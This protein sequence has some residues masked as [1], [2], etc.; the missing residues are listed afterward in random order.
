MDIQKTIRCKFKI[1]LSKAGAYF[2]K[3]NL[4]MAYLVGVSIFFMIASILTEVISRYFFLLEPGDW[5]YNR[6]NGRASR[7]CVVI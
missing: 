3:F 4:L 6:V 1:L 7:T 2:D 5:H